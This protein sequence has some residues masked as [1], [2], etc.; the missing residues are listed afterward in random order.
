[1][2]EAVETESEI[3]SHFWRSK[4]ERAP[5]GMSQCSDIQLQHLTE[6]HVK[7][8]EWSRNGIRAPDIHLI[9]RLHLD[10]KSN[11]LGMM[12]S[13]SM[14]SHRPTNESS[15]IDCLGCLCGIPVAISLRNRSD[16]SR[17]LDTHRALAAVADLA[18]IGWSVFAESFNNGGPCCWWWCEQLPSGVWA[19][20]VRIPARA[21]R[22]PRCFSC[23]YLP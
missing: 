22:A 10:H 17:C 14:R 23:L 9:V 3:F 1:M 7:V 18:V 16:E 2:E 20:Y 6:I 11:S 21:M 5:T 4:S 13:W 19:C 12:S 8:K 15:L